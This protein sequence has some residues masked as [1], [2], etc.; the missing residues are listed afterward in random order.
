LPMPSGIP[1]P[2]WSASCNPWVSRQSPDIQMTKLGLIGP[3][4]AN[5]RPIDRDGPSCRG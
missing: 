2:C 5:T 3:V 4:G 1:E